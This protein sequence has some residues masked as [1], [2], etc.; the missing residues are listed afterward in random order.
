M[1]DNEKRVLEKWITNL[2]LAKISGG[3]ALSEMDCE[4]LLS[5]LL[6]LQSDTDIQERLYRGLNSGSGD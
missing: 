2:R 1:N 6:K 5:F 3:V 4:L